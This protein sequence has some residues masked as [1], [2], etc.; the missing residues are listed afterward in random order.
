[1]ALQWSGK[2]K[3]LSQSIAYP[4]RS[5]STLPGSS[6][7]LPYVKAKNPVFFKPKKQNLQVSRGPKFSSSSSGSATEAIGSEA[8]EGGG[9]DRN[10]RTAGE[11]LAEES[12]RGRARAKAGG[13]GGEEAAE[14]GGVKLNETGLEEEEE[15][16]AERAAGRPEMGGG[17]PRRRPRL[18]LLSPRRLP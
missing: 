15:E 2:A 17:A 9:R 11:R 13:G 6:L 12:R 10:R 1:M 8:R 14:V 16:E 5:K 7:S 18:L 3:A 4:T